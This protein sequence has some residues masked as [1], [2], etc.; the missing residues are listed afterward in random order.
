MYSLYTL[1]TIK[2]QLSSDLEDLDWNSTKSHKRELI[3]AYN[4]KVGN[5]T[6]CS[7]TFY[8]LYVKPNQEGNGYLVY[9][10][11][12]DQI[13]VTKDYRT[14]SVPEDLD[15][16]SIN[17]EDQYKQEANEV[18]QPSQITSLRNKFRRSSLPESLQ[19]KFLRLSLLV[20]LRYGFL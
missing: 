6:L 9:R 5:K 20:S 14:V 8:V 11:D 1:A 10:L 7:K 4:N 17:D 19:N 3:I 18:L 16:T 2:L 12:M 13:V 15:H